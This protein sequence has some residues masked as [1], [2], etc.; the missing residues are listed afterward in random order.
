MINRPIYGVFHLQ[1]TGLLISI[2]RK[3][4][5]IT[6][7]INPP[8][9]GRVQILTTHLTMTVSFQI[10]SNLETKI[11]LITEHYTAQQVDMALLNKLMSQV[12]GRQFWVR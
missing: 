4:L 1:V 2:L 9:Y 11:S 12:F 10:S 3:L 7:I 5:F 8:N 6:Y